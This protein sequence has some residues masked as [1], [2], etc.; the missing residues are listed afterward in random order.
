[1]YKDL[2]ERALHIDSPWFISE[3]NFHEKE[4]ELVIFV[5]FKKGSK[6]DYFHVEDNISGKFPV[7]DTVQKS[8][9]HLNFFEHSCHITARVPRV[10]TDDGKV[11]LIKTPWEGMNSGFTLLFEALLLQ[12]S[13]NMPVNKVSKLTGISNFRIWELLK[14][15]VNRT[16]ETAD[17]SLVEV[18]GVD[19]TSS[20]KGHNYVT[21]FVDLNEKK[22]IFIT[23]G[24]SNE[25]VIDFVEDLKEHHGKADNIKQVCCD[26]SPAF[27][28]GVQENLSKA[29]LTFDKFHIVKIINEAVDQVRREEVKSEIILKKSR[30][31][32]LKNRVNLTKKE[33]TRFTTI[34]LSKKKLKTFRAYMIRESFQ[35]IYT[36]KDIDDFTINLKKWYFWATHSQLKPIIKAAK[37]IKSHWDGVVNWM[38][39]KISNGILEGFNSMVQAAK[40]RARGFKNFEYFKTII[41]LILG[42]LDFKILNNY[43]A[44]I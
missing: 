26:M 29:E 35:E 8:W 22:V 9:Q 20:K 6:F 16:L 24:K 12:L 18:V 14:R 33:S 39:S 44:P 28:K 11:R 38:K 1:M 4:K 13:S 37:T 3:L 43:Y 2:F 25:T 23:E 36:S 10:K 21:L 41:Y 32:F 34:S 17:Y 42:K 30:Y 40:A 27:I 5:D 31:L 7:H 15:Y 19:E